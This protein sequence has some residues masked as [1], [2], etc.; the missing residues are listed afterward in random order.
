[1]WTARGIAANQEAN[2]VFRE[3]VPAKGW[4]AGL[5]HAG[6]RKVLL[7]SNSVGWCARCFLLQPP[8]PYDR[9]SLALWSR[10]LSWQVSASK[11]PKPF[12]RKD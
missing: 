6:T 5:P 11:L 9:W 7:A 12:P 10:K 1:M 3:D 4:T 8:C 2:A